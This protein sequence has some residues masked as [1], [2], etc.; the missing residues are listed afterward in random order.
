M[1]DHQTAPYL[2]VLGADLLVTCV[3]LVLF[4]GSARATASL[5]TRIGR[6]LLWSLICLVLQAVIL[7]LPHHWSTLS[8]AGK[9]VAQYVGNIVIFALAVWGASLA[10]D[11]G[12]RAPRPAIA[13]VAAGL[14]GIAPATIV[15]LFLTCALTLDCV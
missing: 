13:G 3:C 7:R 15:V 10:T 11:R 2:L 12:L 8:L 6:V 5:Q 9:L 1:I 4:V 14:A